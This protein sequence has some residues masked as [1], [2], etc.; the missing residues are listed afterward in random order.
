M[1]DYIG[2]V[3]QGTTSTR[4]MIFDHGG[5]EIARHQLEHEQILP[6]PGW[7]EHDATEIWER[8]R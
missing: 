8:T 3:D 2:A 5:N 6:K 1:P 4:F 7:V